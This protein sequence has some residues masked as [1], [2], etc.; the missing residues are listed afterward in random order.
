MYATRYEQKLILFFY[1]FSNEYGIP[2]NYLR[3]MKII[4]RK[5]FFM[6]LFDLIIDRK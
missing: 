2:N 3:K 6:H 4:T 1:I 5:V